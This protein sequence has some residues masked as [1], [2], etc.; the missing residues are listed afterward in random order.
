MVK[1]GAFLGGPLNALES[2]DLH[3]LICCNYNYIRYN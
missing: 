1:A 2:G 3:P